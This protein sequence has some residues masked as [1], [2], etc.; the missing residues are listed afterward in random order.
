MCPTFL[1]MGL[2]FQQYVFLDLLASLFLP[3]LVRVSNFIH[4]YTLGTDCWRYFLLSLNFLGELR[5]HLRL[6]R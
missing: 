3:F 6:S 2:T 5:N 1:L 4:R